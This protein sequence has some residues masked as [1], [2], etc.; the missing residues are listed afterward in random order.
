MN[1]LIKADIKNGADWMSKQE[2]MDFCKCSKTTLEQIISDL[3]SKVNL[4]TQNHIKKGG[5]YE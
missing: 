3:S 5:S 4:A 2:L 1:D